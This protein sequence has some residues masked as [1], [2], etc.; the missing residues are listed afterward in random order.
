M[1]CLCDVSHAAWQD[2]RVL[3]PGSLLGLSLCPSVQSCQPG[4]QATTSVQ[5]RSGRASP[6]FPAMPTV[7]GCSSISA[8]G[9]G[10]VAPGWPSLC[11]GMDSQGSDWPQA[12]LLR[13]PPCR[14]LCPS[15]PRLFYLEDRFPQV[16]TFGPCYSILGTVL[17]QF[18]L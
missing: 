16:D 4:A 8:R 12:H 18:Q 5:L 3:D 13:F 7:L 14:D 2:R 6:R 10:R 1:R 9:L 17:I 11:P 15:L